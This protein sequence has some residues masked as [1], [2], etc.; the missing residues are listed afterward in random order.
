MDARNVG[1]HPASARW[2]LGGDELGSWVQEG[3]LNKER[4]FDPFILAQIATGMTPMGF[5]FRA[6]SNNSVRR[7]SF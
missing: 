7:I 5:T 3:E 2:R 6:S 1:M 4:L